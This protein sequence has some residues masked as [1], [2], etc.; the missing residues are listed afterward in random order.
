METEQLAKVKD[1]M[2][3]ALKKD[4]TEV[5]ISYLVES[6]V[7]FLKEKGYTVEYNRCGIQ[8]YEYVISW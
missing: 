1:M 2:D 6:N 7:K 8:S 4:Y 5:C 3:E